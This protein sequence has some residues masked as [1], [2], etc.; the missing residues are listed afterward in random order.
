MSKLGEAMLEWADLMVERRLP[1]ATFYANTIRTMVKVH[2]EP[3]KE[4]EPPQS[5]LLAKVKEMY[6][7]VKQ[8]GTTIDASAYVTGA[9]PE[10]FYESLR[11]RWQVVWEYLN[12][13]AEEVT[14][15]VNDPDHRTEHA[16]R[17]AAVNALRDMG[18]GHPEQEG[19]AP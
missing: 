5:E 1:N 10:C 3:A 8:L 17:L 16:N 14:I 6:A 15:I 4:M 13:L 9:D 7:E 18:Y 11:A 19:I 2:D 12:F